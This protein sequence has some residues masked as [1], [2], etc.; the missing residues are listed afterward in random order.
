MSEREQL[1]REIAET[2][3]IL[4]REVLDFLLFI[5]SRKNQ[6][7]IQNNNSQN[8]EIPSFLNFIDQVN[9]EIPAEENTQLPKDLSKNLDNY[10]YGSPKEEE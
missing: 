8:S 3:D 1:I 10:L 2:P 9:S 5:K 7:N 6:D 4:V